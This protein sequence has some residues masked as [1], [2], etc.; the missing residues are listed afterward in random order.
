MRLVAERLREAG[1]QQ[2]GMKPD[3][4]GS[5]RFRSGV[6]PYSSVSLSN[7]RSTAHRQPEGARQRS[8][9]RAGCGGTVRLGPCE[10]WVLYAMG[11]VPEHLADPS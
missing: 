10:A 7:S 3:S 11:P 6:R 9:L 8:L 4:R 2:V 5:A 1:N